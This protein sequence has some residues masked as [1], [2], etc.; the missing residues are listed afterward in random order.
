MNWKPIEQA[1]KDGTLVLVCNERYYYPETASYRTYHP[2]AQ[3]KATWRSTQMG[4][5]IDP[6]HFMPLPEKP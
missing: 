6:T 4:N 2:N 3:G 5:K 1:P